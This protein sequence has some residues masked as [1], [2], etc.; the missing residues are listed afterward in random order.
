[1]DDDDVMLEVTLKLRRN[2]SIE[3]GTKFADDTNAQARG[4][5]LIGLLQIATQNFITD[6][7]KTNSEKKP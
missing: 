1:M 7:F 5:V 3:R 2:G 6:S 4:I